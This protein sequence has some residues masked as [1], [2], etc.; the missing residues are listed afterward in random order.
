MDVFGSPRGS[1]G[2][3]LGGN[4]MTII[5]R[6][7]AALAVGAALGTLATSATAGGFGIGT[8]SGSGTGNAFAGGAAAADD[9]SVA[10]YNPAAIAALPAGSQIAGALHMLKPSFKFQNTASTLPIGSGEGGDGGGWAFVPNA[11]F[12]TQIN[13]SWGFGLAFN[14]PF[15][16]KTSYDPGWRGRSVAIESDIK[17]YNVNPSVSYRLSD[18]VSIG[19]GISSQYIEAELSSFTGAAATGNAILKADDQAWGFNVGMLAQ[20]GPGT[21]VGLAYRSSIKYELTGIAIFTGPAGPLAGGS[22]SA[23]IRVPASA[24]LSAFHALGRSWEVMGDVTWTGWSSLKQLLVIRTTPSILG[25]AGSVVTN[26]PFNWSDTWRYSVGA[27]YRMND[28]AKL[29]FGAAYDETPTNDVDRTARLPDEDRKWIAL[30]VQYR[31]SR[32]GVLDVGYAHEF[33][34]DAAVNNAGAGG[35]LIGTFSNKADILSVQY[36]HSF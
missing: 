12:T 14:A 34:K 36:S 1:G 9:A 22:I 31:T 25:P 3:L 18:A 28:R 24:S 27:N 6:R 35:R 30:G 10:W 13:S 32:S 29:R 17:T 33:I 20:A 7:M 23:D 26:L 16:L 19:A 21:R 4:H 2:R 15:G 5:T 11:F 8:Q